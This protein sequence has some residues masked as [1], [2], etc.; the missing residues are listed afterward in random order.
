MPPT[1][2]LTYGLGASTNNSTNTNNACTDLVLFASPE[3]MRV[4]LSIPQQTHK[5]PPIDLLAIDLPSSSSALSSTAS[6]APTSPT[7]TTPPRR[8]AFYRIT[9]LHPSEIARRLAL[10]VCT[11]CGDDGHARHM[12]AQGRLM[13]KVTKGQLDARLRRCVCPICGDPAGD[14]HCKKTCPRR[15]HVQAILDAKQEAYRRKKVSSSTSSA[16]WKEGRPEMQRVEYETVELR[17]PKFILKG[18]VGRAFEMPY[19]KSFRPTGSQ[20]SSWWRE[21]VNTPPPKSAKTAM[22]ASQYLI[23]LDTVPPS[24]RFRGAKELPPNLLDTDVSEV[25]WGNMA[26]LPCERADSS[27]TE[28]HKQEV[29]HD[30]AD[31]TDCTCSTVDTVTDGMDSPD[32]DVGGVSVK[33]VDFDTMDID[34]TEASKGDDLIVLDK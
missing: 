7:S 33:V 34:D 5:M 3:V 23:D 24:G 31:D 19:K 15:I 4:Q 16:F 27:P 9:K 22:S 14:K 12:C 32:D 1:D 28:A 17:L 21:P 18:N 11:Y 25:V 20:K 13:R 8:K 6:T 26:T 29:D 2:L 30:E 10:G